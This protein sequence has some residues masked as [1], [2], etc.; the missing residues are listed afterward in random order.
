[1]GSVTKITIHSSNNVYSQ[2]NWTFITLNQLENLVFKKRLM[3]IALHCIL[4]E[5][6]TQSPLKYALAR[7]THTIHFLLAVDLVMFS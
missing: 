7:V 5:F 3:N 1:M 6:L 2:I 4:F